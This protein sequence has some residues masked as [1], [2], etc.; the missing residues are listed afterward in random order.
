M[1]KTKTIY[2][3]DG[4][5]FHTGLRF[6]YGPEYS[7]VKDDQLQE[8]RKKFEDL[9]RLPLI[10]NSSYLVFTCVDFRAFW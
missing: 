3:T 7:G 4:T 5:T 1:K 10:F 6:S 8:L 9:F 2:F